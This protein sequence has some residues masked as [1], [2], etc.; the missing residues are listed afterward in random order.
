MP[1]IRK[2]K[3]QVGW[4]IILAAILIW[5]VAK[6]FVIQFYLPDWNLA[7]IESVVLTM[8]SLTGVLILENIFRFFIPTGNHKWVVMA[9]PVVLAI[10]LCYLAD[11]LL[12]LIIEE[13]QMLLSYL[14][15]A[16]V[17][18]VAFCA[19][20]FFFWSW[21]VIINSKL[22]D[23]NQAKKI[24]ERVE[25]MRKEAEL[26]H[27]KQQ[28]QPHFL[29]NSLNSIN[30]LIKSRPEEA[31]EMVVLLADFLRATIK[32]D[33]QKWVSVK[34]EREILDLFLSI[35]KVRFGHRLKVDFQVDEDAY[36]LYVPQLMIQPLLENAVK[37]GLYGVTGEVLVQVRLLALPG[38]MLVKISN[39]YEQEVGKPDG[40]GFGL[41]AVR[42][43]LYLLFG[44]NDLMTIEKES[45]VFNLTLKIP[46]YYDQDVNH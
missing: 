17:L 29:F 22:E 3:E 2:I 26:Y 13:N 1:I 33:D 5:I 12:F 25:M 35:E 37:H 40:V 23:Q 8:V 14:E 9:L 15:R 36:N 20:L 11:F 32:K 39:T 31:R 10:G 42:R 38:Y 45:D 6:A 24:E 41:E 34:E 16:F 46:Q 27:L 43:R 28:L 21:L 18:R 30:A 19:L 4:V 7:L 44:R